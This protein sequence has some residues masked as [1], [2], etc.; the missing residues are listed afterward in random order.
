MPNVQLLEIGDQVGSA[1][2]VPLKHSSRFTH[3]IDKIHQAT[4]RQSCFQLPLE[5]LVRILNGRG[6]CDGIAD[7]RIEFVGYA[8]DERT[9]G[10][11]FF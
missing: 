5:R 8:G 9:Q 2:Q 1:V 11:Q 7:R 10:R 6:D 3:G 4:A